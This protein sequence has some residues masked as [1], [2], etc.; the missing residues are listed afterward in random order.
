MSED[1]DPNG[2]QGMLVIKPK[3]AKGTEMKESLLTAR[4]KVA[5]CR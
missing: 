4:R 2:T 5:S 3:Q 1:M